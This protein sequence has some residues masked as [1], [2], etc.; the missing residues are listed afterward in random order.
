MGK[1]LKKNFESYCTL[2]QD[3]YKTAE[4]VDEGDDE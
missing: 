1:V 3:A 2:V 4:M